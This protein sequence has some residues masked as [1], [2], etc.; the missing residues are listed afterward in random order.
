MPKKKTPEQLQKERA[1]QELLDFH[2]D[3]PE[4]LIRDAYNKPMRGEGG[5]PPPTATMGAWPRVHPLLEGLESTI[6]EDRFGAINDALL[7]VERLTIMVQNLR[8]TSRADVLSTAA[9]ASGGHSGGAGHKADGT[10]NKATAEEILFTVES[11]KKRFD[12][13]TTKPRNWKQ[14][15]VWDTKD[16]LEREGKS[17]SERKIQG[18]AKKVW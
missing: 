2:I 18:L 11:I 10:G 14:I 7:S 12:H 1:R 3:P 6:P 8:E 15:V 16:A 13:A 17:V 9:R 4:R 5:V